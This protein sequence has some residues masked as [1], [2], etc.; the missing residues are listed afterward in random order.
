MPEFREQLAAI[1]A[2]RAERRNEEDALYAARVELHTI[3]KRMTRAAQGTAASDG[4]VVHEDAAGIPMPDPDGAGALAGRAR[5]L[6]RIIAGLGASV[7]QSESRVGGLIAG[8]YERDA[9]PRSTLAKLDD[10]IPFLLFPVRIETIFAPGA[11]GAAPELWV[12]IYPDDIVVHTHESTLTDAEVEAGELY[13]TEFVVAE[14]L[15]ADRDLRRRAAWRHLVQNLSGPRAAWVTRQTKPAD[16]ESMVA[17]GEARDLIAFLEA[18]EPGLFD[19]LRATATGEAVRDA[20]D[21]AV[22]AGDGDA[23]MRL[24]ADNDWGEAI[25]DAARAAI[26]GFPEHDLT[27]T[28]AWTRAPRTRVMPDRFVLML[29]AD[30]NSAPRE[31]VGAP[32]P[33]VLTLG[34]DPLDAKAAFP[35]QDGALTY[36]PQ[37]DWMSNF[38]KAVEQGMGFRVPLNPGEAAAGFARIQ[39][40]G[41]MLSAGAEESARLVE[42]LIDNHQFGPKGFSIVPQG[43]P[44]NN[45]EPDGS[46]YSDNDRYDDLAFFT[47]IEP[48][49]FDPEDPD[50]RR[51]QTDGRRLA[52]ALG[53]SYA[54]MQTLRS[55]D[56]TDMLEAQAM[57]A[58]LF[59]STLGYWLRVWMA[60]VV[61][62]A[63]ARRTRTF[64]NEYV[65]G[66]GPLPAVRVGDQPYGV[67]VTSDLSRWKYPLRPPGEFTFVTLDDLTP[68]LSRLHGLVSQFAKRWDEMAAS[69]AYVGK[70]GSDPQDVLMNVLGL[71]PTSVEFFQRIGYSDEYLR[72]LD[73]FKDKGRYADELASLMRNAPPTARLYLDSLGFTPALADVSR[74]RAMHVLWQHYVTKLDAPN[75]VEN[76]P[77]SDTDLLRVNYIDWLAN[78]ENFDKII[79]QDFSGPP[80]T[81]LLYLMLRNALMLQMHQGAYDWLVQN[82]AFSPE[83][84]AAFRQ[85][86]LPNVRA[87]AISA[88][89]VELMT[90]KV[91]AA[92]SGDALA[93]AS[94]ANALW[95]GHNASDYEAAYV[96]EQKRNLAVLAGATT[97]ALERAFVEH[98]DCCQYRLDAWETGLFAQRL[99]A[100]RR[101]GS[102]DRRMGIYLGA[103]GWVEQ[104]TPTRKEFLGEEALPEVLRPADEHAILEEDD[105]AAARGRE[106][107]ASR[108]GFVHAPSINHA[109]AS[110]LLRSAYLGHANPDD[111]E[112]FSVN[113]SSSRVRRAEFV[114]QG[115]RNGQPIEALLGYQFERGLHDRTSASIARDEL[116]LLELN[117][118]MQAYRD[119]FPF[120]VRE[121][122]QAGDAAPSETVPPYNVV[123]GL[124]LSIGVAVGGQRLRPRWRARAGG[125]ARHPPGRGHPRRTRRAAA[126]RSTRSRTC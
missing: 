5:E 51:S 106:Q 113:L 28:D 112:M 124:K 73:A 57:N 103:F 15:R 7:A 30:A 99:A 19:S 63:T 104:V 64:F 23:L 17:D 48:P 34:P 74:M 35:E 16:W 14:H 37:F 59:P 12:R 118:F 50:P 116:P 110:A 3:Q 20:L 111:A 39:V 65:T 85:T 108:G 79:N 94:V 96:G 56:R 42:E 66:R 72:N 46:G 81:S 122:A 117:Q 126:T 120:E 47:E 119:S 100:Q 2:A 8:L 95:L 97:A 78:A 43:T 101:A 21:A 18:A 6:E 11:P 55:A 33:D 86:T 123:N 29:Y 87:G 22:A 36:G 70:P 10:T 114:L 67:L 83:L 107:G 41:L 102:Q 26:Q 121:I 49:A 32:I 80:Q 61:D 52:D 9:H 60:P 125:A 13:W 71:H 93:G 53:V 24:A 88:T 75:L 44:T 84:A 4:N 82:S 69:A 68:F 98:L 58:A 54:P 25:N 77:P 1:A 89:K 62:A 109:S 76:R 105:A 38:D 27:K 92:S 115:M 45:T 31:I 91:G 90:T 40:L